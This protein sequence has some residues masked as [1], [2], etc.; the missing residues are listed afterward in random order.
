MYVW[1]L[2]LLVFANRLNFKNFV[3]N[4]KKDYFK[5]RSF[6]KN[7]NFFSGFFFFKISRPLKIM[8]IGNIQLSKVM[9]KK[10]KVNVTVSN[11][12]AECIVRKQ[13]K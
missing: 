2:P 8:S 11:Y 10:L 7:I 1:L 4:T 12:T 3:I 9:S 13:Q 6:S 5:F